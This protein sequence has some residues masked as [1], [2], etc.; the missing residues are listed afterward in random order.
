MTIYLVERASLP[1]PASGW[2]DDSVGGH[3]G[4]RASCGCGGS[5]WDLP[6]GPGCRVRSLWEL[7]AL[8]RGGVGSAL[9]PANWRGPRW[10]LGEVP[11][12]LRGAGQGYLQGQGLERSPV[13]L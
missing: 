8:G 6:R 11:S 13:R 1:H 2:G 12:A 3:T 10:G 7:G 4:G 5:P 9:F